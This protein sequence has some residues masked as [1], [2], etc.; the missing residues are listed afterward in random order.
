M[1][2]FDQVK[3]KDGN[4]LTKKSTTSTKSTKNTPLDKARKEITDFLATT[5]KKHGIKVNVNVSHLKTLGDSNLED[6]FKIISKP[7]KANTKVGKNTIGVPYY[8]VYE[9]I[10]FMESTN[11]CEEYTELTKDKNGKVIEIVHNAKDELQ[12]KDKKDS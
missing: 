2:L 9:P 4:T 8:K 10:L 7:F 5:E 1:G 6:S 3:D 12:P 11:I